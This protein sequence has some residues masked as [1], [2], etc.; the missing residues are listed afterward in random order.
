MMTGDVKVIHRYLQR[1]VGEL[2]V[3]YL[4]LVLPFV[5]GT[6]AMLHPGREASAYLCPADVDGRRWTTDRMT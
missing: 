5:Q 1:E 4:W 6:E 2:V 3:W